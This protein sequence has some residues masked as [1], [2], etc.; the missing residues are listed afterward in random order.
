MGQHGGQFLFVECCDGGTGHDN[1]RWF[2]GHAIR[3]ALG[4]VDDEYIAFGGGAAHESNC[5]GM[6]VSVRA[7]PPHDA[8]QPQASEGADR[9]DGEGS[10]EQHELWCAAEFTGGQVAQQLETGLDERVTLA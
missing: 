10:R 3:G 5:L 4:G 6:P 7:Q 2:A 8:R 9:H 1:R